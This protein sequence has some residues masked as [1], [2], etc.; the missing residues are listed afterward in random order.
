MGWPVRR[1]DDDPE[2]DFE[3]LRRP[4]A[5][6]LERWPDFFRPVADLLDATTP[7]VDVEETDDGYLLDVELPGV[8]R[9][10]L[11][12]HVQADGRLTLRAHRRERERRGVLRHRTRTTGE[13]ALT[14]ALPLAVDP[15][16]VTADL[17]AGVLH[18]RV[19]KAARAPRRTIK[20]ER[21]D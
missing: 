6:Q 12:L 3:R 21:R 7:L 16:G 19:P 15:D 4:F 20:V 2:A 9:E 8:A 17:D 14:L 5:E 1:R 18:V 10:A 11:D 13:L